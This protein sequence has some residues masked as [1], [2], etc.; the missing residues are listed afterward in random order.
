[1]SELLLLLILAFIFIFT[2]DTYI[3]SKYRLSVYLICNN[4]YR[5]RPWKTHIGRPLILYPVLFFLSSQLYQDL[6]VFDALHVFVHN[7]SFFLLLLLGYHK[8]TVPDLVHFVKTLLTGFIFITSNCV[9]R[10]HPV[11]DQFERLLFVLQLQMIWTRL[12]RTNRGLFDVMYLPLWPTF[13]TE[14]I[15]FGTGYFLVC[16]FIFQLCVAFHQSKITD[17]HHPCSL[18]WS[19][20]SFFLTVPHSC[21]E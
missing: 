16:D 18:S 10:G 12:W 15:R 1:M 7:L 20:S 14:Y 3:G 11:N 2:P 9:Q 21:G 6:F 19:I 8:M 4:R 13:I 5:Y 17:E